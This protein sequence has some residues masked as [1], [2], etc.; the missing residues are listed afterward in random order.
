M[1][2]W[3]IISIFIITKLFGFGV[4]C[5]KM[6]TLSPI[7]LKYYVQMQRIQSQMLNNRF[8]LTS[9]LII[10]KEYSLYIC[11]VQ[12]I[13]VHPLHSESHEQLRTYFCV[14]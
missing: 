4:I 6:L 9:W 1:R 13:L 5:F 11:V 8:Q 12:D 7:V 3:K 14:P 2:I 10:N